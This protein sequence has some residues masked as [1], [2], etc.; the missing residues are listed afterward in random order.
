MEW[1]FFS[2][3]L[4]YSGRVGRGRIVG[5]WLNSM[6]WWGQWDDSSNLIRGVSGDDGAGG[7]QI[8]LQIFH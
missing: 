6:V 2:V 7:G 8:I 4:A 5:L 3:S 1:W